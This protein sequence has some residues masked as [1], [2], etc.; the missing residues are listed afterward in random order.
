M[1]VKCR[2]TAL[3]GPKVVFALI[4]PQLTG[5]PGR[6]DGGGFNK[7]CRITPMDEITGEKQPDSETGLSPTRSLVPL[8]QR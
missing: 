7:M 3:W 2:V 5:D 4:S 1:A 6:K 8:L